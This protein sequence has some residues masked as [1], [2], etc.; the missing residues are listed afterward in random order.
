MIIAILSPKG[1]VGKTTTA[2]YLATALTQT[3]N[4]VTL[5]DLDPQGSALDWS[6]RADMSTNPLPFSVRGTTSK[7][8]PADIKTIEGIGI[9]DPPP[10]DPNA[11]DASLDVADLVIVPTRTT[12]ADLTR[13]WDIQQALE[14]MSWGVLLTSVRAGTSAPQIAREALDTESVPRFA[15]EIPLRED[16]SA[17]YGTLPRALWGYDELAREITEG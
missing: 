13:I 5:L 4:T 12:P 6:A 16:I 11:L 17:S 9:I 15:T 8:L 1:G 7:T 3:G 2:I 14:G 10:G